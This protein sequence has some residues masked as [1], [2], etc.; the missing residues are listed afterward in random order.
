MN[1]C[2]FTMVNRA[3]SAMTTRT[4]TVR[5]LMDASSAIQVAC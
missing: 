3:S 2:Q 1:V 4:R 5:M